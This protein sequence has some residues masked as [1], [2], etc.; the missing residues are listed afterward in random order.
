MRSCD[1]VRSPGSNMAQKSAP[2][3]LVVS[4]ALLYMDQNFRE[5]SLMPGPMVEE[6]TAERI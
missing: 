6:S 3:P 2:E 5:L 1:R 4:G